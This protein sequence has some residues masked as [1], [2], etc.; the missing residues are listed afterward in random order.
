MTAPRSAHRRC[1]PP[2]RAPGAVLW[3]GLLA[4]GPGCGAATDYNLKTSPDPSFG[5]DEEIDLTVDLALQRNRW[6][7]NTTRCQIQVAFRP[8]PGIAPASR[9]VHHP[10][11]PGLCAHTRLPPGDPEAGVG[12][13]DDD[14]QVTG[15]VL[16]PEQ[17]TLSSGPQALALDGVVVAAEALRYEW[18]DCSAEGFPTSATLDL[19]VPP[20][21]SADGVPSF[22]LEELVAVGPLLDFEGPGPSPS[23]DAPRARPDRDLL[24]TWTLSGDDPVQAGRAVAPQVLVKLLSQDLSGGDDDRWLVCAPV[25]E[26]VFDVPAADLE[27]FT[28]GRLD[29][30]Q[31]FH[32]HI[33]VHSEIRG[34]GQETPWGRVVLP[35]AHISDGGP[36]TFTEDLQ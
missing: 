35:R 3:W 5:P 8:N 27:E 2:R 6:G 16:G 25:E 10:D 32:T 36:I 30:P 1:P 24:V 26:G 12:G 9:V 14:W 21:R 18:A 31:R 4:G 22:E 28:E 33:D 7:D 29:D 20:S 34:E 23:G 13:A 17:I 19:H 11:G 15:G